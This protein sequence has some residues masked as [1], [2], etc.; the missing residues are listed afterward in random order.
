[1]VA[2]NSGAVVRFDDTRPGGSGVVLSHPLS[3]LRAQETADVVGVLEEAEA[4]AAAGRWV[5]GYVAYEA[6]AAFDPAL[7][8]GRHRGCVE[9]PLAW[10]AVFDGIDAAPPLRRPPDG[11]RGAALTR[12]RIDIDAE[13]YRDKV[14]RIRE[15]I[16][17]GDTY[18]VNLTARIRGQLTGDPFALYRDL[19]LA[20]ASPYCAYLD[21]GRF[22]VASAS[23]ELFFEWAGDRIATR[24]MKGTGPRGRSSAEDEIMAERLADSEKDRAENVMI[25]DL[26]RNDVG[27]IA[28]WGSVRVDQL[29]A[30]ER[31]E[32]LW[33]LTS[34]ISG[35]P[36]PGT[37]LV[38]V[39]G[40]LFPSGSVTGA[41]KRRTMEV[42]AALEDTPRGVYCG[43]IGLLAPPGSQWRARF[44]VAIR[45]AVVDR[46]GD[47]VVYGAGGGITWD[48]DPDAE[49]AELEAKTAI[50]AGPGEDCELLETMGYWP[51]SGA[52][53]LA[54]HLDRLA[55]SAAY[56]GFP[57]D[58][59]SVRRT[60]GGATVGGG[61]CRLRVRLGRDGTPAVERS[62][63]P[64]T[65]H[66]PVRLVIDPEP[67]DPASVWLYHK[68]T[69]RSAYETRAARHPEADDVVL[70]NDRGEVTET[71]IAN[72]AVFAE[73]RWCTPPISAGCL[74]G[75]ER[76][77]LL[78]TGRLVERSVTTD[79]LRAAE[80]LAVVSSLRGWRPARLLDQP[81]A[82][83]PA[84]AS[85]S[86]S[87]PG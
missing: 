29:F 80:A 3:I 77:R 73:G 1:V 10:F 23:P 38:D 84:A 46:E 13:T 45:T 44:S 72:L 35:T 59:E 81:V 43:A 20:Q 49:L 36:R 19:A 15:H 64:E 57:Y 9:L 66:E 54:A 8:T 83:T 48:S 65:T 53:N 18:Q 7:A 37:R 26:L 55:R 25:V 28:E 5:A 12:R 68:T 21:T 52:R 27:R 40:A 14:R 76:A 33:Q 22:V 87:T 75:V 62:P 58:E 85:L 78:A 42:I 39:F 47:G 70:V 34:T 2:P 79:D 4:A 50:L 61:P 67:V 56:F 11:A 51:D 71:T 6:A 17:A 32:T 82:G 24:P 16:A 86:G 41:P 60:I 31:Y 63:L 30:L 74:P 69:R